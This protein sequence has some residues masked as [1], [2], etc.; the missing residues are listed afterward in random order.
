MQEVQHHTICAL[1]AHRIT[2]SGSISLRHRLSFSSFPRGTILYR[3]EVVFSLEDGTPATVGSWT[4][5]AIDITLRS[6]F[7]AS[8]R[9]IFK[10]VWSRSTIIFRYNNATQGFNLLWRIYKID[11][12]PRLSYETDHSSHCI[13]IVLDRLC[14][15]RSPLLSTSRLIS[16]PL[17]TKMFHFAGLITCHLFT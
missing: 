14:G 16:I 11:S 7:L 4:L 2:G 17:A 1:F 10:Q 8:L 9:P 13:V 12:Y 6:Q 5:E 3:C 15:V